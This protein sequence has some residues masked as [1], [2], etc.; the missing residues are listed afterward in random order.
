MSVSRP[1]LLLLASLLTLSAFAQKIVYSEPD[2][3]D[4]R[5]TT[6]DVI[7]KISNNFLVYKYSRGRSYVTAFD[8]EMKQLSREEQTYLPDERLI[9]V[10]FFAYADHAYV[11]YE[12]QKRN[13]VYC[14][15]VKIDGMGKKLTEPRTL[16]TAHLS[17]S[18][19]NK[20]Y[21]VISSED[22][23][24]LMV[25][26]IN[27]RNKSRYLLS[28]VLFDRDLNEL[29][30]SSHAIAME[31]R[32]DN[33]G[34]FHLD[35]EG[36]LVFSRF[37]R[38]TSD[39]VGQASLIWKQPGV[40]S[41]QVSEIRLDKMFLDDIHIKVDNH[42]KRY[43][44]TSFYTRARRGNI[45]GLFFYVW[46]R[47]SRQ[48]VMQNTVIMGEEL[49]REARGDAP[50]KMAFNDYF[51]RN[52]IVRRDGGFIIGAEAYYTTSRLNNW[53][54]WDYLYG[55]P[56]GGPWGGFNSGWYGMS[57]YNNWFWRN[58]W[59]GNQ[60]VRHHAD[61]IAIISFDKT[62]KPEWNNVI[63][64]SQFDD[65]SDDQLSYQ[66][67]NTGGALHFLFNMEEKRT[68]LLNDFI[69]APDGQMNRNPTL[70]NLDRNF[71]F[72]PRHGKQVSARQFIVPCYYRNYICFAKIEYT[73]P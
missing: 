32:D 59:G 53:N 5:R 33:L 17:S 58:R 36:G 70:K 71:E 42:N 48:P 11:V 6:F 25:F 2:R 57:P 4:T 20:I 9:N 56:W 54:R 14:D 37:T 19:N 67:M 66:I 40:D 38:V 62:G 8:N 64:K 52:L 22:K 21:T 73:N 41:L 63:R 26:K 43:F 69:L 1:L 30:R 15:M 50:V 18:T 61:N 35:N 27:S 31:E 45:E 47:N 16:D 60:A 39:N 44:L 7:G 49:R 55:N 72:L 28:T 3:E 24:R 23:N 46:D 65:E 13:V 51:I 68:L 10:D 34:Q 29:G 12:H